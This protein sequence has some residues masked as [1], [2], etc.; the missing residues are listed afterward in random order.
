MVH[1]GCIHLY[2][3]H[4]IWGNMEP[5]HLQL[6]QLFNN[7]CYD[8]KDTEFSSTNSTMRNGASHLNRFNIILNTMRHASRKSKSL[9]RGRCKDRNDSANVGKHP[10]DSQWPPLWPFLTIRVQLKTLHRIALSKIFQNIFLPNVVIRFMISVRYAKHPSVAF[11][12]KGLGLPSCISLSNMLCVHQEVTQLHTHTCL[13]WK[14][15]QNCV[16]TVHH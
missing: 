14:L 16:N 10:P 1:F 4:Q 12:F 3:C 13:K 15:S 8:T 2:Q 11:G 6:R 7:L 9:S 5:M